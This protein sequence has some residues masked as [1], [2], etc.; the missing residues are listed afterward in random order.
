MRIGTILDHIDSGTIALPEFQRGYVWNRNQVRKLMDSLYKRHPIGSLLV[1]VTKVESTQIRGDGGSLGGMVKLLLDGQQR[2]TSLYGIIRGRPPRF[3]DGSA[4]A[5]TGLHFD[6]ENEVFEFYAPMKM[7]DNPL[8]ID[9]TELMQKGVVSVGM[10][11]VT[12]PRY[13]EKTES[14][15]RR[16]NQI[17]QIKDISL[18]IEEVTGR[19][20]GIDEVVE[21]FNNVNSGGTRLSQADLALAKICAQWPEARDE[22]KNTLEHWRVSGYAFKLDWLLRN[23]NAVVTGEAKYS[24]LDKASVEDIQSG[25]KRVE[26]S[27]DFLLNLISS[28][29]GLDHNRVIG[30]R[31]AFAV[32]SRYVDSRGGALHDPR[33]QDKLLYWYIHSLLWGRFSGSVESILDRDLEA[34]KSADESGLDR[35]ISEIESWRGSLIVRPGD[36]AGSTVG[37]RFYPMLYLLSRVYGARDWL[38]GNHLSSHLLGRSSTLHLHHIFPKRQLYDRDHTVGQVNAIA[39]FSF[40][41]QEANLRIS[42]KAPED[43]MEWVEEKH[44]GAL[45]SHWIPMDRELWKLDRYMDFLEARRELLAEAANRFLNE[46]LEGRKVDSA[47]ISTPTAMSTVVSDEDKELIDLAE[48]AVSVGLPEPEIHMEVID[49]DDQVISILDIAW[50]RGIQ[51]GLSKPLGLLTVDLSSS[52]NLQN[53]G[54]R[55]FTRITDLERYLEAQIMNSASD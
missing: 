25:L 1:W 21:I 7:Q 2:V 39:N 24:A 51:E 19:D 50:P 10:P 32:M 22:F 36:F 42:D 28:R 8:W 43:Y 11:F 41:T 53:L 27:C 47:I 31:P 38:S 13:N 5:F 16:L 14:Y 37:A 20:K 54:Y 9:V 34:I 55:I 33:E 18:H 44:P 12:D 48:W 26:K 6:V 52:Q 45:A 30:A 46:L 23:I 49:E 4:Q 3:F 35:L 40:L 17:E 29:L 15:L